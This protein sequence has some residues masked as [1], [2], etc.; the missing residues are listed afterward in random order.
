[1]CA[2]ENVAVTPVPGPSALIAALSVSG[3]PTNEF[4]FGTI[5]YNNFLL[6][7]FYPHSFPVLH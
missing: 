3:L 4:T 6:C 7:F 2:S 5:F 1:M